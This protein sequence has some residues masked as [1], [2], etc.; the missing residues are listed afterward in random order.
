MDTLAR[1]NLSR[2]G[3]LIASAAMTAVAGMAPFTTA[4]AADDTL[5]LGFSGGGATDSFDPHAMV[6]QATGSLIQSVFSQ[7]TQVGPDFKLRNV[8]AEEVTAN[9]TVD[10]WDVRLKKG[11]EFHNG[12]TLTAD[13]L[14]YTV[15]RILDPKGGGYAAGQIGFIDTKAIEKLD[16]RTVRFKLPKPFSLF[17]Q[18]FGDGG[19]LGVVPEG[20]DGKEQIGT[21]PYKMVNMTPGQQIVIER[22]DNYFGDKPAIARVVA[23]NFVDDFARVNALMGG[24]IDAMN[25]L[26]L[27]LVPQI[28]ATSGLKVNLSRTGLFNPFSMRTDSG[29]F[30][31]NRVR[32]AFRLMIDREKVVKQAFA[33]RAS[34]CHD[35]YSPFD[36]S[37]DSSLVR[38]QDLD[39]AKALLAE[40]GAQNLVVELLVAPVRFGMVEAAQVVANQ[41]KQIGVTVNIKKLDAAAARSA[42]VQD[43]PFTFGLFPG[44]GYMTMAAISDG[45]ES[46]LNTSRFKDEAFS[47]LYHDVQ[48]E[49]D[50]SARVEKIKAMQRI[51]FEKG[52][53]LNAAFAMGADAY[54]DKVKG[55]ME[56]HTGLGLCRGEF[57]RLSLS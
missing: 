25:Q 52:G 15:R 40:A 36:P 35:L 53:Y 56:D 42:E 24:Q 4:L 27:S 30:K 18:A 21:G 44:L 19:I 22:F 12:K 13:D 23:L 43:A 10:Q 50:E 8:L 17:E 37:Y 51:Q 20:Y 5:R 28:E 3:F 11:V 47:K 57:A 48:A 7:V 9:A 54:S 39:K 45:P 32:Q 41:A 33:G 14:I 55:L 16:E 2:R 46:T 31:D 1:P 29:P 6:G 49:K 38:S 26:P 34:V